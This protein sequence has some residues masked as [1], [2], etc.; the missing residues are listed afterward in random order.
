MWVKNRQE[1]ISLEDS[2]I[3]EEKKKREEKR[4][5]KENLKK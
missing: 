3:K 2:E 1:I 4:L 5:Q